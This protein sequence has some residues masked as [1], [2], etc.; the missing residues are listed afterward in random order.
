VSQASEH[1]STDRVSMTVAEFE[2]ACDAYQG[3]CTNCRKITSDGVEPD[4]REY[5]CE[6]C[7]ERTVYGAE[8][9]LFM[10]LIEIVPA[11]DDE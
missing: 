6:S 7:G 5:E 9:T 8:E 11:D 3:F 4:A 1:A 2:E 10:D